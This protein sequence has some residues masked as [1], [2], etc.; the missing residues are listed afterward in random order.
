MIPNLRDSDVEPI[1]LFA[2]ME[3]PDHIGTRRRRWRN[4]HH[5]FAP[6]KRLQHGWSTP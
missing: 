3:C 1:W 2:I 6:L 4:S 5:G